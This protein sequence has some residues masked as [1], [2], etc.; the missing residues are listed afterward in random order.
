MSEV[1][2]EQQP[3][4]APV[5]NGLSENP[6]GAPAPAETDLDALLAQYTE[7][8]KQPEPESG[9]NVQEGTNSAP[10]AE[11]ELDSLLA[12]LNADTERANALQAEVNALKSA[13]HQRQ[14]R[15]AFSDYASQLQSRLPDHVPPDYAEAQLLAA[16]SRDPALVAAWDVRN[17][18]A[19][20]RSQAPALLQQAMRLY[21]QIQ[22]MPDTDARKAQALNW[23]VQRGQYLEAVV[24]G[25]GLLRKAA[26]N[27]EKRARDFQPIDQEATAL[28]Q[29]I[30]FHMK[31]ARGRLTPEPPPNF[32][33]MTDNEFRQWKRENL[34]WE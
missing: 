30:A 28:K 18:P 16:A 3:E 29:E 33:R 14:E 23:V 22:R 25:P 31:S 32:G 24:Y 9:A 11:S 8:T 34:G 27:I 1:V 5:V 19:A 2:E 12:N 21:Q 10:V 7:G 26:L 4:A 15:E 13:E 20:E 17:V 6:I